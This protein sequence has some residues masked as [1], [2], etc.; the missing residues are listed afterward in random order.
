M[1]TNALSNSSK[2]EDYGVST[3]TRQG[4]LPGAHSKGAK[5]KTACTLPLL[6]GVASGAVNGLVH[7]AL[8][9][10]VALAHTHAR[11]ALRAAIVVVVGLAGRATLVV[12]S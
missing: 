4:C 10:A 5:H 11:G 1:L 8:V 7:N 3:Q 9:L 6:L 2:G 12:Y